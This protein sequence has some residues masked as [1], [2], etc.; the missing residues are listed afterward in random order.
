MAEARLALALACCLARAVSSFLQLPL[1]S[2]AGCA[3]ALRGGAQSPRD[4]ALTMCGQGASAAD[5]KV[6][7]S[8]LNTGCVC[9]CTRVCAC[10]RACVHVCVFA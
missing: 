2:G 1:L 7:E 8:V 10:V 4:G 3:P 5:D 6:L 9:V